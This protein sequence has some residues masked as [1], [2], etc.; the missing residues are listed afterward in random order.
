MP[1]YYKIMRY[2][3]VAVCVVTSL[4][5]AKTGDSNYFFKSA[6]D[7]KRTTHNDTSRATATE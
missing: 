7:A 1:S 4:R 6:I 3:V 5:V 2:L